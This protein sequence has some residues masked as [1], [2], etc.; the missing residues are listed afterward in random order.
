MGD[1]VDVA[2]GGDAGAE[3]EELADAVLDAESHAPGEE[4]SVVP[5]R[6][7]GFPGGFAHTGLTLD[8]ESP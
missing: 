7:F 3:V 5:D 6:C 1:L 8:P 2:D 4:G